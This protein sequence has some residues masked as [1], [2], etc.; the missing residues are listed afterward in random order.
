MMM[1]EYYQYTYKGLSDRYK[2]LTQW[3]GEHHSC[4][5]QKGDI[6]PGKLNK[7]L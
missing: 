5:Q 1:T 6:E 7:V 3:W 2:R 4:G